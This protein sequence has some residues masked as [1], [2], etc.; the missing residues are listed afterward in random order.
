[1]RTKLFTAVA[2]SAL[3]TAGAASAQMFGNYGYGSDLG[4]DDFRSGFGQSGYF[5]RLDRDRDTFLSEG[6]FATGLF[7]DYDRDNDLQISEEEYGLGTNRYY[8]D[9]YGG[10]FTDYDRD[11][12]GFIDRTEFR[13]FYD[14]EYYARLDTDRDSLLS[15]DEYSTG[16]YGAADRDRNQVLTVEEEGFFE[17]WF[18]GDDIEVELE[19]V[20][21]VY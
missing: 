2:L 11:T 14:P 10:V 5:G 20:G 15:E 12:S 9:A 1:M 6:E 13:E 19:E 18:D 21:E 7:A 3:L 4:Y 17:G 16:L 8:G